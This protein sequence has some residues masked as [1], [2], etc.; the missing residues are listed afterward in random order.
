MTKKDY[1]EILGIKKDS[2]KEE[3]KKAYKKLAKQYHPDLNKNHGDGEKFK[4][5]SEAYAV[6]SDE[7]KKQQYDQFGHNGFDQRFSQE[8]IFRGADFSS[9]FQDIFG[10]A[11]GSDI[12]G[13]NRQ[14]QQRGED[15]GY[16]I[17]IDFDEAVFGTEKTIRLPKKVK[18]EI[19]N[20]T[21]AKEEIQE[22]CNV[23]QGNGQVKK[24]TRTPFG[25]FA[26]VST[27][28]ECKGRGKIAKEKCPDCN[29][30]L[31]DKV[32]KIKVNIPAGI[33]N[34]NSLRISGEGQEI[35]SG[36]AGDLYLQVYHA[37]HKIF[38]REESD[39]YLTLPVTISQA[40]LGTEIKIPGLE[41]EIKI[42]INPGTQSHTILRLKG[43][44]IK[45]LN[46]LGKGDQFVKI[47]VKTPTKLNKRQKQ[48]L[49]NLGKELKES[50]NYQKTFFDKV[51]EAFV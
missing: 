25:V 38:E 48:L 37:P 4:E 13:G 30:G 6:L 32:K 47:L 50:P 20:G 12:F 35:T 5:I 26:Q 15:L 8:D 43:K 18:C 19:C 41:D 27:C 17:K 51:R 46:G 21:G 39:V 28:R 11:F 1:Y 34:G 33:E 29:Y 9:I 36:P 24:T 31:Q 7:N 3:I 16:E 23:C 42:K 2:N 14:R 45:K 40:A 22:E 49:Q 10:S 44:G